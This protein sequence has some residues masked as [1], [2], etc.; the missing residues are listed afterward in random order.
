MAGSGL[1]IVDLSAG[2][3]LLV[4][5]EQ[6]KSSVTVGVKMD[7]SVL[8]EKSLFEMLGL[9]VSPKLHWGSYIVS[10]AKIACKKIEP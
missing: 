9:L 7:G 3:V 5:F 10:I 1:L 6:C 8:E 2:E 4:L